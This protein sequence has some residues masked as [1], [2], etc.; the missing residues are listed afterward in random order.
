VAAQ[1]YPFLPV[2]QLTRIQY[3]TLA[4]LPE[5]KAP[6]LIVHSPNDEVIPYSHSQKL[7]AAAN[8]PKE[9]L[10]LNGGHND[11]FLISAVAYEATFAAFVARYV[12]K[13]Q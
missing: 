7:L 9:F 1:A 6:V 2:R 12:E 5:I 8:E 11:G 13:Q 4:R 3:N 10:Q